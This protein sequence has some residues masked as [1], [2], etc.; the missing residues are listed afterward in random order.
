MI[1]A[2]PSNPPPAP[3][4]GRRWKRRAI[5]LYRLLVVLAIFASI[6]VMQRKRSGAALDPGKVLQEAQRVFPAVAT[7]G[8]FDEGYAALLDASGETLG[9]ATSTNPQAA[10]VQGYVGP[11]ELL[12]LLD[13][14]RRVRAVRPWTSADTAG[15]VDKVRGDSAFWRQWDGKAEA[16]LGSTAVQPVVTSGATLT[17]EAMAKG[18]AARFGAKG[19]TERFPEPLELAEVKKWFPGADRLTENG[20]GVSTAW[21]GEQKRGTILRSARI[22]VSERGFNGSNDVLLALDATG[23]L[24]LGVAIKGSRDNEPYTRDARED[25]KFTDAFQNKPVSEILATN[26][27]TQW[28]VSGATVTSSSVSASVREM[29]RRHHTVAPAKA[30]DWKSPLAFTWIAGGL[31]V[32]FTKLRARKAVRTGFA[33]FSVVAGGLLLGLMVG[34]DQLTGWAKRGDP[35]GIALPLLLLSAAALLVPVVSGKNIYCAHLCPHGAAQTLLGGLRKKRHALPK[36]W[37]L[38]LQI[39][40]WITLVGLWTVAFAGAAWPLSHAE[41]FEIWSA[42]FYALVPT[43]VFG[44]GLLVAAFLPQGYCHYGCPTGALLKFLT[45]APGR[46]L[47]RDTV[48]GLLALTGTVWSLLA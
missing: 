21:Q 3:E 24:V 4:A 48:A 40:P 27:D 15:H 31:L 47:W 23:D 45:H 7:V 39:I 1:S 37:H 28:T 2:K 19:M 5:S 44:I 18:L 36:R 43:L 12:V 20:P 41:P 25:L 34:Q 16:E 29:L 42:G 30:P 9:W 8:T 22:G 14:D 11:S 17:S 35:A 46:W 32:G 26:E 10:A 38:V 6:H 13:P 33:V